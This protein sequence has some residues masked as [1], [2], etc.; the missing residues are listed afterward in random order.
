MVTRRGFFKLAGL[1]ACTAL[2]GTAEA[3]EHGKVHPDSMGMLTDITLCVGCRSCE[4]ACNQINDLEKPDRPSDDLAGLESPRLLTTKAYPVVNQY[5][6]AMER[7]ADLNVK[8][9]CMH[10]VHPACVSACL[11]GALTK[12]K[13]GPVTWTGWQCM[14]CRYCLIACPFGVPAYESHKGIGPR[15]LK[16]T[17]CFPLIKEGKIPGCDAACPMQDLTF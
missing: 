13:E 12:H 9:Q 14:G 11:L 1:S 8:I 15:V 10:C 2:T 5:P 3:G 16:C 6:P 4:A 7:G 17:L